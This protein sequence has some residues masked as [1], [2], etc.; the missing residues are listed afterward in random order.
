VARLVY[1]RHAAQRSVEALWQTIGRL[2][3]CFA[4]DECRNYFEIVGYASSQTE[5][6]LGTCQ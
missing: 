5:I 2:L 3:D 6:A 4:P 1:L